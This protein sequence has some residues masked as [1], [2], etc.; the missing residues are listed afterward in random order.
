MLTVLNLLAWGLVMLL[1][2]P[3]RL[4]FPDKLHSRFLLLHCPVMHS[5][6]HGIENT[7]AP[8]L[9]ERLASSIPFLLHYISLS[10]FQDTC[11]KH[12]ITSSMS[13]T[14]PLLTFLTMVKRPFLEFDHNIDLVFEIDPEIDLCSHLM[15]AMHCLQDVALT[16]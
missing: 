16:A 10:C 14:A 8:R 4:C 11:F 1:T 9:E 5:L 15:A 13:A 3:D 7:S 2:A 12:P 6:A